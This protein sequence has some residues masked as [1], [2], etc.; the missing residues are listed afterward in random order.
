ML[1]SMS[2]VLL[3][4]PIF[5]LSFSKSLNPMQK[6]TKCREETFLCE[7]WL[8]RSGR[9]YQ[10]GRD[11]LGTATDLVSSFYWHGKW[12]H[13]SDFPKDKQLEGKLNQIQF[14]PGH[15]TWNKSLWVISPC[16][17]T[18]CVL[19]KLTLSLWLSQGGLQGLSEQ[20][21]QDAGLSS[22]PGLLAD[23]FVNNRSHE[24]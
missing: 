4:P 19:E 11:I 10:S 21:F 7:E 12:K 14:Y 8:Q 3:F 23:A 6:I 20:T 24:L 13:K 18:D 17:V 1:F 15:W 16:S 9:K 22:D 2:H 5:L